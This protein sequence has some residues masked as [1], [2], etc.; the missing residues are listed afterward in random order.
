MISASL[1]IGGSEMQKA[2]QE[3]KLDQD[4]SETWNWDTP[5]VTP[6][7][8]TPVVQEVQAVQQPQQDYTALTVSLFI[9]L[10]IAILMFWYFRNRSKFKILSSNN[11]NS[12]N[13]PPTLVQSQ[14]ELFNR[15]VKEEYSKKLEALRQA[16]MSK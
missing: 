16:R 9:S 7:V 11:L 14:P 1:N 15:K 2:E 8:T 10:G 5:K 13:F 3:E 12:Q 4:T 6:V